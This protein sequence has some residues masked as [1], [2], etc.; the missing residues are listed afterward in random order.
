MAR[1]TGP[2]TSGTLLMNASSVLRIGTNSGFQPNNGTFLPVFQSYALDPT[3]TITY[4]ARANQTI[5]NIA[6]E[7]LAVTAYGLPAV[8][9]TKSLSGNTVINGTL[10]ANQIN[11]TLILDLGSSTLTIGGSLI[12]AGQISNAGGGA[13]ILEGDSLAFSGTITPN[14]DITFAGTSVIAEMPNP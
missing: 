12:G 8:T 9:L 4:D 3:S 14:Y 11:S 6:Y 2:G 5:A 1:I 7:N 13:V 10:E